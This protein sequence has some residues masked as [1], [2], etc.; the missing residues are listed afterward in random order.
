MPG[1]RLSL[2]VG[3]S[4]KFLSFLWYITSHS[5]AV[6]CLGESKPQLS[7]SLSSSKVKTW[8]DCL[9]QDC[10]VKLVTLSFSVPVSVTQPTCPKLWG[11]E[12]AQ[13]ESLL[14]F[15]TKHMLSFTFHLH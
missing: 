12:G 6:L 1:V 9:G 8:V 13:E 7:I 3:H 4:T 11:Y 2:Y 14:N 10:S 5:W 15:M